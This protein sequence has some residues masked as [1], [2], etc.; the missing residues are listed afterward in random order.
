MNRN[1]HHREAVTAGLRAAAEAEA[2]VLAFWEGG[3]AA[4]G[5]RD[6]MSDLDLQ[7][8]VKDDFVEPARTLLEG[9]LRQVAA[10]EASYILPQPTWHGYWQGFYR[11]EGLGP[12]LLVDACIMKESDRSLLSEP[13]IHGQAIVHFDRTGR[14]GKERA[15]REQL[16]AAIKLRLGRARAAAEMFHLFVDKEAQR[17]RQ[18]DALALYQSLILGPLMETL[19]IIHDP[20]RHN[21]GS[22]YLQHCLPDEEYRE[23]QN[24]SFVG[25]AAELIVKKEF[26]LGWLKRNLAAIDPE[27]VFNGRKNNGR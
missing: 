17:G 10:I 18:L 23:L 2:R 5:R 4:F 7:L 12:Y 3:S 27:K 15:D 20:Y 22:R 19:R 24:L 21:F 11:L 16:A 14:V 9:A 6:E 13:E 26:A 8:L 1:N 25:S